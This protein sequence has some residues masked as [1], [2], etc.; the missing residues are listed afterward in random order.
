MPFK[1]LEELIKI[2][3]KI[4]ARDKAED[5]EVRDRQEVAK[6]QQQH[7][8]EKVLRPVVKE[9]VE[10]SQQTTGEQLAAAVGE[11]TESNKE[12]SEENK[13]IVEDLSDTIP[14]TFTTTLM[15]PDERDMT[16]RKITPNDDAEFFLNGVQLK[17][18]D[19]NT[20][21]FDAASSAGGVDRGFPLTKGLAQ[22]LILKRNF[23]DATKDDKKNYVEI[24]DLVGLLRD[25]TG[26]VKGDSSVKYRLIIKPTLQRYSYGETPSAKLGRG[27]KTNTPSSRGPQCII[28]DIN[29]LIDDME[30]SLN[31]IKAGNTSRRLRNKVV[32]IANYLFKKKEIDKDLY[33]QL[34]KHVGL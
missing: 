32:G 30:L 27:Y 26:K 10:E 11:I 18:P 5:F 24:L 22:L 28:G 7:F 9:A 20:V 31:S 1:N 2:K 3:D 4:R 16:K 19:E 8:Q 12:L 14:R 29:E 25:A 33:T 17:F 34:L 21:T 6:M 23:P 13:Q 15:G